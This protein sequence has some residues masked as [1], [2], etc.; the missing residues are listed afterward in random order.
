M[1]GVWHDKA[2]AGA[3]VF[4]HV[5]FVEPL[6]LGWLVGGVPVSA[7]ENARYPL[8]GSMLRAVQAIPVE[9]RHRVDAASATRRHATVEIML[10]VA[11]DPAMP[12]LLVAPE[13][14][15]T[16][17]RALAEFKPGAF[18][19]MLPVQ[20]VAVRHLFAAVDPS[21]VTDGPDQFVL[22]L[23]MMASPFNA[24]SVSYLPVEA[25]TVEEVAAVAAGRAATATAAEHAAASA[26]THAFADRVAASIAAAL[27]VPATRFSQH[28]Q[29]Q[30]AAARSHR[31]RHPSALVPR[32][33]LA[34]LGVSRDDALT[35]LRA[36]AARDPGRTARIPE[37]TPAEAA[38][39]VAAA[40]ARSL[41]PPAAAATDAAA[42]PLMTFGDFLAAAIAGGAISSG[43][44]GHRKDGAGGADCVT[45]IV[46]TDP[47]FFARAPPDAAGDDDR[48]VLAGGGASESGLPTSDGAAPASA[49]G[50]DSV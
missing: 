15:T 27:G 48:A 10:A 9:A 34:R 19:P 17:G 37:V 29:A 32:G 1:S 50:A 45:P 46:T 35:A 36:F 16:N 6:V 14:M 24:M 33:G 8:I 2:A 5:T 11:R 40:A 41:A 3:V 13:G 7:A 42:A 23:R 38:A 47:P 28:D 43:N 4:N 31:Y 25:P 30:R 22:L 44:G 26:A 12:Q 20:P 39:L 21:W 49:S 18:A